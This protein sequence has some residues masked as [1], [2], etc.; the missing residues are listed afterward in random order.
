MINTRRTNSSHTDFVALVQK[1]DAELAARDGTEHSFYDQFNKIGD[2]R[3]AVVAY[4]YGK[5]ISCGAIKEQAPGMM[6]VKRMYTAPEHRGKGVAALVLNEL[7][8]WAQELGCHTCV[9]ETGRRQPEAIRL[10]E[11]SGYAYIPNYGPYVGVA[12]SVCFEKR[13]HS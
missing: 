11:K 4:K 13:L 2:L 9:L 1:L 3:Y 10:Y 8:K 12:N 6:E 7:E 5:P